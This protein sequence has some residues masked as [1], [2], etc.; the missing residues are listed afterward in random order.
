MKPKEDYYTIIENH[1]KD[2][3]R[4]VQILDRSF[5]ERYMELIF[6]KQIS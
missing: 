6:E 3:W 1:S 2:G 5:Q 4:L